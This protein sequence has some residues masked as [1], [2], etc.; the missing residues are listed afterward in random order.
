MSKKHIHKYHKVKVNGV[1]VWACAL[2]DCNHHM[3][4]HYESTIPGKGF[5]C[6]SCGE[7]GIFDSTNMMM[8][9]PHCFNC[10]NPELVSEETEVFGKLDVYTEYLK[11]K[12][13][14]ETNK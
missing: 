12:R 2:P 13:E 4:K 6:W 10:L 11:N 8:L 5:I 9:R 1:E 3:P 14:Q 7:M